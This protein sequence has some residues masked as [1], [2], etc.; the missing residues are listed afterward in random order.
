[1]KG[2]Q[3]GAE[4]LVAYFMF[5][6]PKKQETKPKRQFSRA[7]FHIVLL[8][9]L[10]FLRGC[11]LR[12]ATQYPGQHFNRGKNAVWLGVE[13]VHEPHSPAEITALAKELKQRQIVYVFVYTSY[14]KDHGAFNPTYG[15]ASQFIQDLKTAYPSVKILAWL[16]LPLDYV[17]LQDQATRQYIVTFSA[18]LLSDFNFDGI[19]FDPEPI[20]DG[21]QNVLALLKE[22]KQAIGEDKILSIATQKAWPIFPNAPWGKLYEPVMWSSDYYKELARATDQIAVMTYDSGMPL[23]ALYRQWSRFQVIQ[24]SNAVADTG[25]ELFFGLP[26]SEEDSYVHHIKAENMLTG[27]T[28]TI[29]GLN[30]SAARPDAVTGVAIYPYWETDAAEWHIYDQLWLGH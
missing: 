7:F 27:L 29:A 22:T 18:Q 26:T 28:G 1:M 14:L 19:H 3:V 2:R 15:Y 6:L 30:D 13:W 17:F 24:I 25:V 8:L 5:V 4:F 20:G 9:S 11:V 21:D 23:A 10:I 16:G 12:P